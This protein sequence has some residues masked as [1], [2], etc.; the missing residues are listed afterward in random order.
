MSVAT[1]GP[2]IEVYKGAVTT[3]QFDLALWNFMGGF[4][5]FTIEDANRYVVKSQDIWPADLDAGGQAFIRVTPT[6]SL[7]LTEEGSRYGAMWYN[8]GE[9][10]PVYLPTEITVKETIGGIEG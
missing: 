6:E 3:L 8:E 9:P 2:I 1:S 5:R 7:G 4:I 10:I